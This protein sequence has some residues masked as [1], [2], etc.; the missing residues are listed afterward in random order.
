MSAAGSGLTP[1]LE[2]RRPIAEDRLPA[3]IHPVLRRVYLARELGTARDLDYRLDRLHPAALLSGIDTAAGLLHSVMARGGRILVIGD[4]DA[5]G[6]TSSA[7]AVRVLR[8]LGAPEVDF[9]VPDRFRYGYG[10]TP[11][12]VSVAA[13]QQPDLILTVDNGIASIAGVQEARRL[14]IE[15]L[16]TDHH[17]PG[18]MLPSAS[19]I[20]NPNQRE[21]RF[22]SKNLAGV[23]VIFYV[24]A[25]LR[26][27]L[28]AAGWF[29]AK[30]IAEPNLAEFLDL[31]ALGTVADVVALDANNRILVEQGLRRIR[32]GRACVGIRALIEVAG[33]SCAEIVASDLGFALGPRLN[34]AGRLANMK[35]GIEC[36]LTDDMA[37]ARELAQRLDSLNRERRDIEGA[38]QEQALA[39]LRECEALVGS[40]LPPGLCLFHPEWHQGVVGILAGRIKDRYHRPTIAFAD[41]G[42][43]KLKGSARSIKGLHIRDAID[44]VATRRPELVERFGG[45]AM[46]AGLTVPA[47]GIEAFAEEFALEV[48]RRLDPEDLQGRVW[49]DGELRAEEHSVE[50][51]VALRYAGPWGQGFPE[52]VFDG[53]FRVLDQRIVG[54]R[55]LRLTVRHP[56]GSGGLTAIAFG[57]PFL[58]IDSDRVHL[59]YRLDLNSYQG[60]VTPQLVVQNFLSVS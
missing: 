13:L 39:H 48:G 11:E 45:H 40:D 6:A 21:D 43:G 4:F 59:A 57:S 28:R 25:A 1:R 9:L 34:A 7:L 35:L 15:V 23:G 33:R 36:L 49:S 16:V 27:R 42:E 50:L 41:G 31:V 46:A 29:R 10:L 14:G 52:P 32:A 37:H 38:M 30:G 5:D 55:H 47:L 8:R 58:S 54:E 17:L 26:Q 3:D 22:P 12:I 56:Q 19:A 44:A 2:R 24:M 60:T 20:V 18:G 51:A 53:E